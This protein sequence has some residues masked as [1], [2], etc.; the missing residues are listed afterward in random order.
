MWTVVAQ[1]ILLAAFLSVARSY[2]IIAFALILLQA[3][4]RLNVV[5]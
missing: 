2:N 3:G 1:H 4:D 5:L